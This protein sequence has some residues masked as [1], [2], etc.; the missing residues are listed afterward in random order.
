MQKTAQRPSESLFAALDED[1]E[2]W[3]AFD[4]EE[5][6][7]DAE[8]IDFKLLAA[9]IAEM[10][11]FIKHARALT[12]DSKAQALLQALKPVFKKCRK[13]VRRTRR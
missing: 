5:N 7:S 8:P 10:D 9:E 4:D 3:E 11:G 2:D 12:H 13:Q 1:L 6:D